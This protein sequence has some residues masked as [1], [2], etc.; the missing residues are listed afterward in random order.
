M[1]EEETKTTSRY[2]KKVEGGGGSSIQHVEH[3]GKMISA[4]SDQSGIKTLNGLYKYKINLIPNYHILFV[5]N[6]LGNIH[7]LITFIFNI[8]H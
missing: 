7:F 8:D 2:R 5:T 4:P 1:I 3:E 6:L